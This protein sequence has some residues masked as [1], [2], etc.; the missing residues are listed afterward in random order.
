MDC[1]FE[2]TATGAD[3]NLAWKGLEV[4]SNFCIAKV[5][6]V[7]SQGRFCRLHIAEHNGLN[8]RFLLPCQGMHGIDVLLQMDVDANMRT[9]YPGRDKLMHGY[10]PVNGHTVTQKHTINRWARGQPFAIELLS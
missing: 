2:N 7:E 6:L 3:V 8:S 4:N 1:Y 5:Q 10:W 9:S